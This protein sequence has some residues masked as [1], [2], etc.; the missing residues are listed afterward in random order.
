[1]KN[2]TSIAALT[3]TISAAFASAGV[4]DVTPG[5]TLWTNPSGE[6]GDGTGTSG[7]QD[8]PLLDGD[9]AVFIKGDRTRFAAGTIYPGAA[10]TSI[11]L[12]TNLTAY[13]FKWTSV[14]RDP[15]G[16]SLT[17]APALRLHV[18]D[19]S[20]ARRFEI[21]WED[22]E[23][24]DNKQFSGVATAV[25]GT[26]FTGDMFTS[27]VYINTRTGNGTGRG[28]FNANGTLITGSDAPT[29]LASLVSIL[30]TDAFI[31][32]LSV[33]VGSSAG[34]LYTGYADDVQIA[35]GQANDTTFNFTTV[36]E[37]AALTALGLGGLALL[38]RRNRA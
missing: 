5:S 26:T 34:A 30:G 15:T 35:F 29:T 32:G 13:N 21:I 24:G 3:L 11:G 23:Q 14:T 20:E 4:V 7:I 38:R 6:N 28:L 31:G 10:S 9:G 18:Y 16:I 17:Q 36:P 1:M 27:S 19:P 22:G 37:P 8:T 25:P 12:L 33:G 2:V